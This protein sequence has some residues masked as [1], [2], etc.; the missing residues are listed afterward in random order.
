MRP[1]VSGL[2][3]PFKRA[4]SAVPGSDLSGVTELDL[5]D[6]TLVTESGGQP[7]EVP[8]LGLAFG[9]AGLSVKKP[10]GASYALIPW[11]S[12]LQLSAAAVGPQRHHLPTT[13]TLEVRSKLKRHRFLV[14][15]VQAEALTGSLG[16][17]SAR[18][19]RG[20]VTVSALPRGRRRH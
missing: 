12:L 19:G 14:P 16:A 8:H 13:A 5:I 1:I 17:M 6:V 2:K 4:T 10:D 7:V 18:Y 3:W 20:E 15:N 11:V 9:E